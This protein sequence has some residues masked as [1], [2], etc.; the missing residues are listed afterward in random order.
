M[1]AHVLHV[2]RPSVAFEQ[3]Q[4]LV[5]NDARRV[6][7]ESYLAHDAPLDEVTDYLM[8]FGSFPRLEP[9]I[10]ILAVMP[11]SRFWPTLLEN[12]VACDHPW[13]GRRSLLALMRSNAKP[14]PIEFF[15]ASERAWFETQPKII[16][17][18]RGCNRGFPRG[19]SW[20]IDEDIAEGFARGK[21]C[22][23]ADPVVMKARIHKGAVFGVLFERREHEILID[24]RRLRGLTARDVK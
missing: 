21:R 8:F 2:L 17:V 11:R 24:P 23:N 6:A 12:Y 15:P 10:R 4:E 14:H 1:Q 7:Y 19:I 16:E 22:H 13:R 5:A 3:F 20:T 9:L 18:Y